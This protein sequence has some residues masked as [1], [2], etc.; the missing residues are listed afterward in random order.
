MKIL[1]LADL[2]LG[3]ILLEQSLIEDQEYCLKQIV[4]KIKQ[5]NIEAVVISG[6]VYDKNIPSLDAV[7]LLNDFLNE[8]IKELKI[9]VFIIAGNHDS[10]DRLGFGSK[11]LEEEGLFIA[12]KYEGSLKKVELSD[13][14]GKLNIYMLPFIKPAEVK[15]YFEEEI[16]SYDDAVHKII[17]KENIDKSQRNIILVHQFV[18]FR[19]IGPRKK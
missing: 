10:K 2:H 5:K 15:N 4:N 19:N 1:H 6:D 18:T 16:T 14:F 3:K 9:K 8:L 17:A 7:N 13:E 12:S 11:I